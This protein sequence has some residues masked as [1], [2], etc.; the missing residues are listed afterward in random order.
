MI[1]GP[2]VVLGGIFGLPAAEIP[3]WMWLLGCLN[4]TKNIK[5]Y[6]YFKYL[7]LSPVDYLDF[8]VTDHV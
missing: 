6:I 4:I 5:K 1:K 8:S 2:G 7:K 3:S